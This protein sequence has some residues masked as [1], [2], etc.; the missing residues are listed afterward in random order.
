MRNGFIGVAVLSTT[1][2]L[3]ATEATATEFGQLFSR[4]CLQHFQ[5]PQALREQMQRESAQPLPAEQA[6][7]YLAGR[8]GEAWA[9]AGTASN[10][11]VSR[12]ES[13]A[14]AVFAQRAESADEQRAFAAQ[15]GAAPAPWTATRLDYS[16]RSPPNAQ[17]S[18]YA[19]Q[20]PQEARSLLVSLTTSDAEDGGIQALAVMEWAKQE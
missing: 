13:G 8:P 17:T 12:G 9:V 6:D 18:A 5:A 4:T 16:K 1:M 20:R 14:C 2:C 7:I 11:V 19:W 10:Y 3:H 15:V